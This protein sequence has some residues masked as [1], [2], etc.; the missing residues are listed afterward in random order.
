MNVKQTLVS[1]KLFSK[2]A[3]VLCMTEM[4]FETMYS[5][6]KVSLAP[7]SK[8]VFYIT[9]TKLNQNRLVT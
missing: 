6:F 7:Q 3:N 9:K 2:E 5:R 1:E 4:L 8:T